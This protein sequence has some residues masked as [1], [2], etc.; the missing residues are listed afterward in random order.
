MYLYASIHLKVRIMKKLMMVFAVLGI[1]FSAQAQE[2]KRKVFVKKD[3]LIEAVYYHEN[4][5]IE[6]TGTFT[7]DGKLHGTWKSFDADGNKTA[8]AEYNQGKKTG[9]WFFW[10]DGVLK[11]VDYKDSQIAKV[12]I[13]ENSK[14]AIVSNE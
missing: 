5:N 2:K 1:L 13:W 7:L 14:E 4:G 9:K 6:Q 8:I 10:N 12:Q 11:E 3:K